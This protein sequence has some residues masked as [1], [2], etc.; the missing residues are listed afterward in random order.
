LGTV[1]RMVVLMVL[2]DTDRYREIEFQ[3][4]DPDLS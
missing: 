3:S 1:Q 4:L 2:V